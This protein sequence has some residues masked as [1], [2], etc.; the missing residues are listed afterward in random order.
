MDVP[1]NAARCP[2]LVDRLR[3]VPG[4]QSALISVM[5]PGAYVPPHSDPG[6]GVIRYHLGLRVPRDRERCWIS[7]DGRK[8]SWA[9]GAGVLFDDAFDHWVKNDTDEARIIL[10]VDILRPM[11]GPARFFQGLAN[12][13]NRLHPGVHRAIAASE[14]PG[15]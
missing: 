3:R 14:T 1:G 13:A 5:E 7:V 2:V 9:D 4:M 12:A 10:F 15:P 6:K 11:R 8:Y